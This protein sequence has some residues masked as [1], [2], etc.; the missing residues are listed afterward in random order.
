MVAC[1][2]DYFGLF[3]GV[4]K[5]SRGWVCICSTVTDFNL[6]EGCFGTHIIEEHE[7]GSDR[8]SRAGNWTDLHKISMC[9]FFGSRKTRKKAN[10]VQHL[11]ML[12]KNVKN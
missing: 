1:L 12:G 8:S 11:G 4:L 6:S 5:M 9:V 2:K 3:R 10:N 7:M